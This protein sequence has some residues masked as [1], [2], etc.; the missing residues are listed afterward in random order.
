[1]FPSNVWLTRAPSLPG[2]RRVARCFFPVV[3]LQCKHLPAPPVPEDAT[4]RPGPLPLILAFGLV[5]LTP[6]PVGGAADPLAKYDASI[7]PGDRAHWAF[8]PVRPVRI[9]QVKN[10][11]WAIIPIDSFILA[12]LEARGWKPAPPAQP[13][14]LLRRITLDLIGL[15]PLIAEQEAFLAD[16]SPLALERL[17][18]RLLASPRYGER[19]GRH[20]LDVARYADTNGYERDGDKP[21]AWRYRDQV[22]RS[23]N[24]DKPFDRFILEQLAGDELPDADSESV[25]ATGFLRLGP[26][27]DEPADPLNDRHDQLDD[28]ISTTSE[29]FLGLT[30]GCCRCHNHKFEPLTMLD[31]YRAAAIFSPLVR[32]A[33]GRT[34][35][36]RPAVPARRRAEVQRIEQRLSSLRKSSKPDSGKEVAALQSKLSSIP[37][38]YFLEE[39]SPSPPA[40]HLLR[41]G[42]ADASGPEV[43]PG[44]PA[45]LVSRQPDFLKPDK[46]TSQRRLTL[47][48]WIARRDNPLTARVIVNRV[49]QYH[50]GSGLVLTPS[51]FGRRG[52]RPS[53]PELLDWLANWF[54]QEGWSVKKLH[55]LILTSNTYRMSN[56]RNPE[57]S[58]IDPENRL[59]WR[60]SPRRLEAEV[61]R[62]SVLAVSGQLNLEMFGPGVRPPIPRSALEG[63]SD[64]KTV[65]RPDSGPAICRRTVYVHVKRSLL[66]PLL[67]TLD[68]CDTTRGAARRPVTTVAPQALML[69]N[70]SFVNEQ[71]RHLAVRLQIE[72]GGDP[73]RQVEHAYRVL[74]CRTPTVQEKVALGRFLKHQAAR[75]ATPESAEA[76]LQALTLACRVLLNLNEFVYPD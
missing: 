53:H 30:L 21:H 35:L 68:L 3:G 15:P 41:R 5:A 27:D 59:L 16:S 28:M 46:Y 23:F 14:Q 64:P 38:G 33:N 61:I 48:R 22:I 4:M 6:W 1:M 57:Y 10:V 47:A 70:G 74:L 60:F 31:Y 26:W 39:R 36:D 55:R 51:D 56:R 8:Q 72:C 50:F 9:P 67:E 58:K 73:E 40:T 19:W 43:K 24:E 42:R 54:V 18:D 75:H 69:F 65:W 44:V 32:P 63:H 2:S 45:V 76:R 49:W 37:R 62:D 12:R 52:G 66:V 13:R 34:E 29:A 11:K 71:A 17:V 25:L 20:W 7:K